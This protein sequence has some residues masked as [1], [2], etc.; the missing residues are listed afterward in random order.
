MEMSECLSRGR[1]IAE[2]SDR[3]FEERWKNVHRTVWGGAQVVELFERYLVPVHQ[4]RQ[5]LMH[6]I[7]E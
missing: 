6:A 5:S 3:T 1:E 4:C 2:I 7:K